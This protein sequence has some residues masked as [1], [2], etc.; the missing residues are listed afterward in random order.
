VAN[1]IPQS[2]QPFVGRS[3]FTHKAGIH[4]SAIERAERAYEHIDPAVVGNATRVLVSDQMGT[5][6]VLNRAREIGI[7]L[8]GRPETMRALVEKVKE[9]EYQ[10]F[11]FE[12]AE[13]SFTLLVLEAVG[14]RPRY[15]ELVDYRVLVVAGGSPEATVRVRVGDEEI[16]AVSLGV[17]PAHALDLAL[18]SALLGAY[19]EIQEFH[20]T[21]FK[22]RILDGHDGTGARTRVHVDTG[23]GQRIWSTMGVSP[24]IITATLNAIVE[25]YEYG[26]LLRRGADILPAGALRKAPP[27]P[28]ARAA[29]RADSAGAAP[30]GNVTL[31]P[32]GE[33]RLPIVILHEVDP[34]RSEIGA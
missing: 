11:Q 29:A 33:R 25:G 10:G 21:D 16:H 20:L 2:H 19:P 3:A 5:S 9:M 13:G 30:S 4:V 22:V 1:R 7:D 15:F 12:D 14:R 26:L 18:R 24:N 32:G 17:G 28:D 27:A 8:S 31:A 34:G 6:N 23:D